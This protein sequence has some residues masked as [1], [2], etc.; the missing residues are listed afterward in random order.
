MADDTLPYPCQC[1]QHPTVLEQ[2]VRTGRRRKV[3]PPAVMHI[4]IGV[5]GL[6]CHDARITTLRGGEK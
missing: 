2:N 1:A 5:T 6:V 3:L 4:E